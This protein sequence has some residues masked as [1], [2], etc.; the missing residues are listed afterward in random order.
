MIMFNQFQARTDGVRAMTSEK[1]AALL[2]VKIGPA[3]APKMP[4]AV[5]GTMKVQKSLSE[6]NQKIWIAFWM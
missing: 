5:S 2:V 3:R 4:N 1:L 6:S